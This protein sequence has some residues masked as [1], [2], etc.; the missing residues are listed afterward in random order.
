MPMDRRSFMKA[1]GVG[2]AM[3]LSALAGC[4][5]LLGGGSTTA[6]GS[7]Q[8]DP[9]TLADTQTRFFGSMK[10]GE[11]YA[12]RDQLPES[13][14]NFE[15]SSDSPV[16]PGD[17]EL[18][19]GVGGGQVSMDTGAAGFFG[20]AAITGSF[21]KSAMTQE[22]ESQGSSQASGNYQGYA[23]YEGTNLDQNVPGSTM[24]GQSVDASA[25]V[26]VGDSA[27][28][29]G[30]AASQG[31]D[32][33]V[34]GKAAV[35]TMIDAEAG[36]APKL[37]NNSQYASTLKN[38]LGGA[39]MVV[40]GEVDGSLVQSYRDTNS[41]MSMYGSMLEGL[42]AGGFNADISPDTTTYTFAIVYDNADN[43]GSTGIPQMVNNYKS[44]LEQQP[45]IN[46]ISANQNGQTITVTVT[47]DTEALLSQ[48]QQQ[49]P[50]GSAVGDVEGIPSEF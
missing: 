11:L 37:A 3:G 8:Y 32:T 43:A 33:G 31:T 42:R 20:S 16:S 9:A 29:G 27:M 35:E 34:T 10:Y 44:R 1:S 5:G 24:P 28:V 48:G 19:T 36:N 13:M 18:A 49:V 30:V 39:M 2:A 40:G 22:I 46:S 21:D 25:T 12:M 15:T 47:G 14:A 26:G 41:G 6:G 4:S 17:I 7:W 45:S 50:M 38:E 23:L